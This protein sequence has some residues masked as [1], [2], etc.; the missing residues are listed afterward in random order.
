[1]ITEEIQGE[2]FFVERIENGDL[3]VTGHPYPMHGVPTLSSLKVAND[4]K[5]YLKGHNP[6][7]FFLYKTVQLFPID[8]VFGKEILKLLSGICGKRLAR[9]VTHVLEYDGAYRFRLQDLF[10]DTTKEAFAT[11]PREEIARLLT[12]NKTRDFK[13]VSTHEK[14]IRRRPPELASAKVE[15]IGKLILLA[16]LFPPLTWLVK[17]ALQRSTFHNLQFDTADTYWAC[18]KQDY[19]YFGKTYE[20]RQ[21]TMAQI[22]F[23]STRIL[24]I[25]D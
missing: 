13:S 22:L 19:D 8:T 2:E 16:L 1:M 24:G 5:R 6:R 15:K 17:R 23:E 7:I 12:V 9:I 3:Y 4:V 20:E 14:G 21:K 11:N 18:M 25:P 10:T